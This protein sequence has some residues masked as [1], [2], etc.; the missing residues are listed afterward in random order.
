MKTNLPIFQTKESNVRRRYRDFEWLESELERDSKIVVPS[1]PSIAIRKQLPFRSDDGKFEEG[2][3][4]DRR[5]GLEAFINKIASQPLARN[6]KC[7][8]MFLQEAVIRRDY[9]APNI[10]MP[11]ISPMMLR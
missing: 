10:L 8:L 1:L 2:F 6:K 4:E 11:N 5:S 7:L 3:I 9:D